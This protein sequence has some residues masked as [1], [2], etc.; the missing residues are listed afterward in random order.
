MLKRIMVAGIVVCFYGTILFADS[1]DEIMKRLS[2]VTGISKSEI[3]RYKSK[4]TLNDILM[5]YV[6]SC[7]AGGNVEIILNASDSGKNMKGYYKSY[8]IGEDIQSKISSKYSELSAKVFKE[9]FK[10]AD[11]SGINKEKVAGLISQ[12]TGV[13][14]GSVLE[15]GFGSG[16]SVNDILLACVIA[17]K[18]GNNLS[19]IVEIRKQTG[20]WNGV[21]ER[22]CINSNSQSVI[23]SKCGEYSEEVNLLASIPVAKEKKS[24]TGEMES[25]TAVISRITGVYKGKILDC[26]KEGESES[27][28][29]TGCAISSKT[30]NDIYNIMKLKNEGGWKKVYNYYCI[31][32]TT[33]DKIGE[34]IS[35]VNEVLHPPASE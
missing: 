31:S 26:Y 8:N 32:K 15:Y 19:N 1:D 9:E 22:Y 17:S 21:Y 28:I 2:S 4:S 20:S 10:I 11:Y 27:D 7:Y 30:G 6:V 24:I 25:S 3:I 34:I 23:N 14:K 5:A 29:I 35:K 12:K 18:T 16:L 33:Q 13:S